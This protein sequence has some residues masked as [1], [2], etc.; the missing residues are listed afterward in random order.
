[1][2]NHKLIIA[3]KKT[4]LNEVEIGIEKILKTTGVGQT[5]KFLNQMLKI[6]TANIKLLIS[7]I[8]SFRSTS[9]KK[10][11]SNIEKANSKF[12][13]R[14]M[15]AMRNI[16]KEIDDLSRDSK[17]NEAFFFTMPGIAIIDHI[18]RASDN[19]GGFSNYIQAYE[20]NLYVGD[21]IPDTIAAL[22]S[23]LAKV[24]GI[25]TKAGDKKELTKD[26]SIAIIKRDMEELIKKKYGQGAVEFLKDIYSGKEN[27]K[28]TEFLD[29]IN[30]KRNLS[31]NDR[32]NAIKDFLQSLSNIVESNILYKKSFKS[33]L[34]IEK[35]KIK[36]KS[37]SKLYDSIVSYIIDDLNLLEIYIDK[38]I[39][40][41]ELIKEN[42]K[43]DIREYS[44]LLE[45]LSTDFIV[46][47]LIEQF[48]QKESINLN[49]LKKFINNL[50]INLEKESKNRLLDF[51]EEI[52]KKVSS[53]NKKE[54]S[55]VFITLLLKTQEDLFYKDNKFKIYFENLEKYSN[56]ND[57]DFIVL[58]K[59]CSKIYKKN[60]SFNIK[61]AENILIKKIKE[62]EKDEK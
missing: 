44:V 28:T 9:L 16:D 48:L 10:I 58:K 30:N 61:E 11:A 62:L 36:Q 15:R 49:F 46:F 13:S 29:L 57:S 2:K 22:E 24:A 7:F 4:Q 12:S 17:I 38:K 37:R 39:K 55:N 26:E 40:N 52:D 6:A 14:V 23:G 51:I 59:L 25:K 35:K 18:R 32:E 27:D 60:I 31:K 1:M 43:E 41:K 45:L 50:P 19:E 20:Q 5:A 33:T 54:L 42:I 3:N 8:L 47:K 56:S 34:I 21:V 53:S